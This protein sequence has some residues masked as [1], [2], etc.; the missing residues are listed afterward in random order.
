[1]EIIIKNKRSIIRLYDMDSFLELP[2]KNIRKLWQL[3]F[4]E[5]WSNEES[6]QNLKQWLLNTEAELN[7]DLQHRE[8]AMLEALREAE[9]VRRVKESYGSAV[10]KEINQA[11]CLA[12][13]NAREAESLYKLAKRKLERI[14]KLKADFHNLSQ[15]YGR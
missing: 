12:R 2:L 14:C 8:C 6:I 4:D 7:G 1:M 13:K 3:M 15:R 10:T 5:T 9:E 11:A